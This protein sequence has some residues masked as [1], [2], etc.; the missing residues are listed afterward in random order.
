MTYQLLHN[1]TETWLCTSKI[2]F[3]PF[4]AIFASRMRLFRTQE[5]KYCINNSSSTYMKSFRPFREKSPTPLKT[6]QFSHATINDPNNS[7]FVI[8]M[9]TSESVLVGIKN[10]MMSP[11]NRRLPQPPGKTNSHFRWFI[12]PNIMPDSIQIIVVLWFHNIYLMKL[13]LWRVLPWFLNI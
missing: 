5:D 9:L 6:L 8:N 10:S 4:E 7:F 2:V 11:Q 13:S 3:Q 12:F 1:G